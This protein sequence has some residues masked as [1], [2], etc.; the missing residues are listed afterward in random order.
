MLARRELYRQS[1]HIIFGMLLVLLLYYKILSHLALFLLIIIGI[2]ISFLSKRLPLPFLSFFLK[3]MEREE[4][5][6]NFPGKGLIFFLVGTLLAVKLF[7]PD[8]ALASIMILAWGDSLS[9]VVGQKIGRIRN[10]F[11]K[12]GEKMLE[13]TLF[14]TVAGFFGA[15]IFVPIPEAFLGSAGAMMAE[16]LTIE[17]NDHTLDD[18]LIV[19][20]VAGTMMLLIRRYL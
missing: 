19:P 2:M 8:I 17:F 9:H 16:V 20:L 3:N 5:Y 13:G 14:G 7:P 18:N 4:D 12:K 11:H 1:F 15:L 6:K 10:I